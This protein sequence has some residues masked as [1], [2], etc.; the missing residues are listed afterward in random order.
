M[1]HEFREGVSSIQRNVFVLGGALRTQG[2]SC[3]LGTAQRHISAALAVAVA[4]FPDP[5][6]VVMLILMVF[7]T[8][9]IRWLAKHRP[10]HSSTLKQDSF[11]LAHLL[12]RLFSSTIGTECSRLFTSTNLNLCGLNSTPSSGGGSTA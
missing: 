10:Y 7:P 11:P 1:Q 12:N 4:N 8:G 3:A 9:R 6:V 2:A 5:D